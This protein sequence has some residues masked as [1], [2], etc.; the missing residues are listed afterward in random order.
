MIKDIKVGSKW[1][2]IDRVFIVTGLQQ[3]DNNQ[4][5]FYKNVQ[6]GD[7]FS[8]LVEAFT[9]RFSQILNEQR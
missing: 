6:T 3:E 7:E 8:C 9:N 4:W 1:S 5:V 2:A